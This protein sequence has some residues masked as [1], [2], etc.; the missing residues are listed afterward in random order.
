MTDHPPQLGEIPQRSELQIPTL[1][2]SEMDSN[3]S[4]D[5]IQG[6]K[7][8]I[9]DSKI[10]DAQYAANTVQNHPA[11]QNVKQSM[12]NGS[13]GPVAES[14][15]DQHAKTRSEFNNLANSRAPPEQ[16]AATGQPLT[17]TSPHSF[18][19]LRWDNP[20]VTAI[21]FISN[22]LLIF[23]I[24]YLPALRWSFK[25]LSYTLACTLNHYMQETRADNTR[26]TVT[27][28][29]EVAGKLVLNNGLASS[30]RPKKYYTIP[31]EALEASL[32]DV[33]QLINFFVI[34]FQRILFAENVTAT[35]AAFFAAFVS[36]W[37]IKFTPL[38]GLSLI[39][40]SVIYLTPLIYKTNKE[41]IDH[42]LANASELAN[43]QAQ[44]VKD[45]T[46]HHAGRYGETVKQ[47]A[48]DYTA[49]AQSYIGNARGRSTSPEATTSLPANAPVKSEPGDAPAYK[50]S[51]FPHAPKQ[52]PV[53][54]AESHQ[55]QYEKSQFG[56]QAEAAY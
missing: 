23:S 5:S 50:P 48:G 15:K 36:Y 46:A 13:V 38:W 52:E 41:F 45:L 40:T 53:S 26:V 12:S 37:L 18:S 49:K 39:A 42:H 16:S 19:Q 33:E 22:V 25:L 3:P 47:Y 27:A 56:G 11:T 2:S 14:V 43:S 55:Q 29:L 31:R 44:Q 34:E 35:V 9:Y 1:S 10:L 7:N 21:S 4:N 54:G 20:R 28:S 51:D 32:E 17:R 30:F 8:A 6:A 24:R